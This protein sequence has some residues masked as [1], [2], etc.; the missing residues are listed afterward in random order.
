MSE[1]TDLQDVE[2]INK[3][4]S[5]PGFRLSES[6]LHAIDK[7]IISSGLRLIVLIPCVAIFVYFMTWA[8]QG[9]SPEWW[10]DRIQPTLDLSFSMTSAL[11]CTILL[12]G[13]LFAIGFHRFRVRL[14]LNSLILILFNGVCLFSSQ[15]IKR[16]L[17]FYL[18]LKTR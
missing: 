18:R 13:Y 11:L 3:S 2:H 5:S 12:T 8:F 7:Q 10:I 14:S 16:Y 4:D 17:F 6:V 1:S 15:S 9:N